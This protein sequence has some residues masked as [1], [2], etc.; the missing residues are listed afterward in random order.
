METFGAFAG[1]ALIVLAMAVLFNGWPKITINKY[2]KP[3][4]KDKGNG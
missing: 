1:M 3:S 2:N 4:K